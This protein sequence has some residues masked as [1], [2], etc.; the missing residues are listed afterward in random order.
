[1]SSAAVR[2]RRFSE[3]ERR[4][5]VEDWRRS[6]LSQSEFARRAG[7]AQAYVSRWSREQATSESQAAS[8]VAVLVIVTVR[9]IVAL[10]TA[11]PAGSLRRPAKCA[12]SGALNPARHNRRAEPSTSVRRVRDRPCRAPSS[13]SEPASTTPRVARVLAETRTSRRR[14]ESPHLATDFL[15]VDA[16]TML[17]RVG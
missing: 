2:R 11:C 16:W 15:T 12:D 13:L 10:T 3:A 6:G 1:M 9:L 7:I 8:L 17:R 5:I 14:F 4:R